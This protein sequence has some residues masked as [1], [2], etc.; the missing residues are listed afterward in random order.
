[1]AYTLTMEEISGDDTSINNSF[2]MILRFSTHTLGGKS[3]VTFYTFEVLNTKN[4]EYQFSKY[5]NSQGPS[6]NPWTLVWHSAF[7]GEFDQGHGLK[8][9]NTFKVVTNGH[10]F[11]FIVNGKNVKTVQDGSYASGEVGMLVNLKGTEVAFS[12][13]MLTHN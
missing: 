13:L 3:I 1:M 12:D 2:G 6:A 11:T 7:G 5:D 4:G 10:S 8:S 9:I